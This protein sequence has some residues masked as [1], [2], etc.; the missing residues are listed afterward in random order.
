MVEVRSRATITED[1]HAPA[2]PDTLGTHVWWLLTNET[3]DSTGIVLNVNEMPAHTAHRLHRHAHAEQAVYVVAGRGR[4]LTES[5]AID[6]AAGDA[7]H[8]PAGEWHGFA[9]PYEEPC[10]I[11][12]IYGGIGSRTD[13]GYE[14]HSAPPTVAGVDDMATKDY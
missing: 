6:V 9:N 1:P 5:G 10:T 8:I 11:L 4:H 12:S 14:L 3:V 7:I 13:A 2:R